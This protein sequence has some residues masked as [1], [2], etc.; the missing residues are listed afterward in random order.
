MSTTPPDPYDIAD[1]LRAAR[2]W[3]R[4]QQRRTRPAETATIACEPWAVLLADAED[5]I[6]R[7]RKAVGRR[8]AA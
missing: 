7:L 5:E 2:L 6:R 4:H 3:L 1:R 8:E